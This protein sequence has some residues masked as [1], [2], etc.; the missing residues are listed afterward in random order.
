MK[1]GE[2]EFVVDADCL[3]FKVESGMARTNIKAIMGFSRRSSVSDFP[4]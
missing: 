1:V 4:R 2:G 3:G